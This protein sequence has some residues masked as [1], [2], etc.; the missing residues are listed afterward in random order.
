MPKSEQRSIPLGALRWVA[1]DHVGNSSMA[2]FSHMVG[3]NPH[4]GWAPPWD[5]ADLSRCLRLLRAVP[6]WRARLPE[7]SERSK[8][9]KALVARWDELETCMQDEVGWDW[10]KGKSAPQTYALMKQVIENKRATKAA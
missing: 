7:M 3:V 4:R 6:E 1:G 9:W 5:P 2:I 10:S 8:I